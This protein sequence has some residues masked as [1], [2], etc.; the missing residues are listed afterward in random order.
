MASGDNKS[1]K[2]PVV[3]G[4]VIGLHVAAIAAFAVLQGCSMVKP[5]N[6][7]HTYGSTYNQAP[8]NPARVNS[9]PTG[10]GSILSPRSN[11]YAASQQQPRSSEQFLKVPRT[12]RA[13]STAAGGSFSASGN[14]AAR[15]SSAARGGLNPAALSYQSKELKGMDLIQNTG[16]Q[17]VVRKTPTTGNPGGLLDAGKTV[18]V[19]S[20]DSLSAIA[21]RNGVRVSDIK[22]WNALRNDTIFVGQKLKVSPDGGSPVQSVASSKPNLAVA[23]LE[24]PKSSPSSNSGTSS[25]SSKP[26]VPSGS[27][28]Y[29]VQSGDSLSV[30]AKRHGVNTADLKAYN[31]LSS[32]VIRIGDKLGIPGAGSSSSAP[33]SP[34]ST[35]PKNTVPV[36][37]PPTTKP[38]E[39]DVETILPPIQ[40]PV[41]EVEAA[42]TKPDSSNPKSSDQ[43][44]EGLS[45]VSSDQFEYEVVAEDTL[46]LIAQ[47]FLTTT[48]EIK[49]FNP[50]VSSNADLKSGMKIVIPPLN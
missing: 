19:K 46:E 49:K 50:T 17:T 5:R 15:G 30:I 1:M 35:K 20:G 26:Q 24:K 25:S 45:G 43:L 6:A 40:P 18:T 36:T 14:S 8:L 44:E 3:F 27:N 21:R 29:T 7:G 39:D 32:D 28:V 9:A 12:P 23:A 34:V 11:P 33:S 13:G 38:V 16:K 10:N 41:E 37:N 42:P 22:S 47:T 2:S 4:T 48:D 31:K